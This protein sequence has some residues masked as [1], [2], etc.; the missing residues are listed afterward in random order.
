MERKLIR[1]AHSPDADDAFMFYALAKEK[2]QD[3][4][5]VFEHILSDIETLNQK[6][7]QGFYEVTAISY[8]AYPYVQDKYVLM[9][10]GGSIGENYG[11]V[12]VSRE[13]LDA[14]SLKGK[15]IAVPGK[16]T[17]ARLVLKIFESEY[18]E[19]F[20]NFDEIMQAVKNGD[21]DAGLI[22]HEGQLTFDKEG[23][24]SVVDLGRWW[25]E[26]TG[27]PLPLGGNVIRRDI[28]E[29]VDITSLIKQS[30]VYS[31]KH[32][33]EA[34]DYALGF[35]RG[36]DR[37]DARR[38]VRMYVNERTI[39]LGEDGKKAAQLLLDRGYEAGVLPQRIELDWI[40]V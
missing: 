17:T 1:I 37:E 3:E 23:L 30:I 18:D 16:L 26:E 12:V 32:E 20:M 13:P 40:E 14:K 19:V 24:Y 2:I 33:D 4:R 35:G 5:F 6:A 38:F 39:H 31:I 15:K 7:L 10:C 21:V 34:L 25:Q 28:G 8:H 9:T 22:I 11:P 29:K 27:L 36:L